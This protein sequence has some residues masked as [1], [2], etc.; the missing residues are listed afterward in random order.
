MSK[1]DPD[2][3]GALEKAVNDAAGRAGA[4]WL[5]FITL[6]AYLL[7]AVGAVTHRDL[8]LEKA[9]KLPLLNVDLPL[10]GFFAA[11]PFFFILF[12]FYV[13]LQLQGI[14]RKLLVYDALLRDQAATDRE[15]NLMRHRLDSF[16][17]VQLLAGPRE[18]GDKISG[19]LLNLIGW[20]TMVALPVLVLLHI[21]FSFLPYHLEEVTWLHRVSIMCDLALI[22][23]FW[24]VLIGGHNRIAKRQRW[25]SVLF[26]AAAAALVLILSVAVAVFPGEAL[27]D[28]LSS[29][30]TLFLFEGALS[31]ENDR[32]ESAFANRLVVADQ[33]LIDP[34]KVDKVDLTVS[35]RGRDLRNAVLN[36]S[37]LRKVDLTGAKLAGAS[38]IGT[39][40]QRG[41]FGCFSTSD[42]GCADIRGADFAFADLIH[43]DFKRARGVAANF[44]HAK[45][46]KVDFFGANLRGASFS[47]AQAKGATFQGASVDG[48]AFSGEKDLDLN[49]SIGVSWSPK[50]GGDEDKKMEALAAT[51][52][53]LACDPDGRPY[54]ARGLV[55]NRQFPHT[56]RHIEEIEKLL[57][58]KTATRC[59]GGGGLRPRDLEVLANQVQVFKVSQ[60][61]QSGAEKK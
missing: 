9:L 41:R 58:G 17:L 24:T 16:V 7:I 57:L 34:E 26:A 10:I 12:H 37:D 27:Y 56:G 32:I 40:L 59:A 13:F 23:F 52:R 11:A 48:A 51:L 60:D 21:Q 36:R 29:R 45:L 54:V 20:I 42:A 15:A 19:Y 46:G 1:I 22:G 39:N 47:D 28:H 3:L 2:N 5:S 35:L 8:L 18:R 33:V 49:G 50:P 61:T 4:L 6:I 14:A 55:N 38:L 31:P 25:R 53:E 43:A 30:L 44:S